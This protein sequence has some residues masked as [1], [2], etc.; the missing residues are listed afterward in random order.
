LGKGHSDANPVTARSK[1]AAAGCNNLF[2]LISSK[3]EQY[4]RDFKE[5]DLELE[6]L[7]RATK[8]DLIKKELEANHARTLEA[9]DKVSEVLRTIE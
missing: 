1:N 3:D 8:N 7:Q 6:R 4:Y 2:T 9:M 5:I